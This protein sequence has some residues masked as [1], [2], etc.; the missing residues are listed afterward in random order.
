MK[1]S[2]FETMVDL[3]FKVSLLA[4][5]TIFSQSCQLAFLDLYLVIWLLKFVRRDIT[6]TFEGMPFRV[7]EGNPC[8]S[9]ADETDR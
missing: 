8:E 3:K 5:V 2:N 9:H 6:I 4:N 1:P 7:P